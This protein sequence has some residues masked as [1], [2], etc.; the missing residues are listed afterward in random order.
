M[1]WCGQA[2]AV[3]D[4]DIPA[5][6]WNAVGDIADDCGGEGVPMLVGDDVV[7]GVLDVSHGA[8][9]TQVDMRGVATI[10]D[11]AGDADRDHQIV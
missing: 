9:A 10:G 2:G 8:A 4:V 5:V 6:R 1:G 11:K 7:E 3:M